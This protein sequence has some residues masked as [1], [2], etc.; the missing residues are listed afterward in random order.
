MLMIR[1][2]TL[3]HKRL[4]KTEILVHQLVIMLAVDSIQHTIHFLEIKLKFN[5]DFKP[6][7][8]E[9]KDKEVMKR[10]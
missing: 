6:N 4:I 1:S 3:H 7:V 9:F 8:E 10:R 2:R 5:Y